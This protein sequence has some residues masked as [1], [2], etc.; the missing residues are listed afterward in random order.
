ML[1]GDL[2]NVRLIREA[3]LDELFDLWQDVRARGAYYPQGLQS[4]AAQR[5]EFE[6]TGFWKDNMGRMV[7]EDKAG[8]LQGQIYC[9]KPTYFD[10]LELAY[11]V[12]RPQSRGRGYMTEAV[13][14]LSDY[15]FDTHKINRLQ[16]TVAA[17]NIGS[18]RVAEKCG[19]TSEGV[20]RGAVFLKGR[21]MDMEMF[22]LLRDERPLAAV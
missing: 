22:S 17:G 16:L 10:A 15:L 6:E 7:I 13:Q 2:I 4:D 3:D 20:L 9:F 8:V 12:L 19:F 5:R 18:V 1:R 11:I 14:L 21:S